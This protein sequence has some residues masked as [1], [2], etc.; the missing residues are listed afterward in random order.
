MSALTGLLDGQVT[1]NYTQS[2]TYASK[3]DNCGLYL[4]NASTPVLSAEQNAVGH[5]TSCTFTTSG[6]N[7]LA[8]NV[9]AGGASL[10]QFTGPTTGGAIGVTTTVLGNQASSN[11]PYAQ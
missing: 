6:L 4:W 1:F 2:A 9:Q 5:E 8:S 7:A 10:F 11:Q 3:M